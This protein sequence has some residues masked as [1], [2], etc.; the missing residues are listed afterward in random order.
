MLLSGCAE[1]L[2]TIPEMTTETSAPATVATTE[3]PTTEVEETEAMTTTETETEDES[4]SEPTT[5]VIKPGVPVM[6]ATEAPEEGEGTY[7]I[8]GLTVFEP[9]EH[10]NAYIDISQVGFLAPD[11]HTKDGYI[12]ECEFYDMGYRQW[13]VSHKL[14][15][16]P[17]ATPWVTEGGAEQTVRGMLTAWEA[18][19]HR[20]GQSQPLFVWERGK[21]EPVRWT[22][23]KNLRMLWSK[24]WDGDMVRT[25]EFDYGLGIHHYLQVPAEEEEGLFCE[26]DGNYYFP[27]N[28]CLMCLAPGAEE[29]KTIVLDTNFYVNRISNIYMYPTKVPMAIVRGVDDAGNE[30][31]ASVNLRTGEVA[32]VGPVNY[33]ANSDDNVLIMNSFDNTVSSEVRIYHY[34]FSD[35]SYMADGNVELQAQ[36]LSNGYTLLYYRVPLSAE[37]VGYRVYLYKPDHLLIANSRLDV[38]SSAWIAGECLLNAEGKIIIPIALPDGSTSFFRWD[39]VIKQATEPALNVCSVTDTTRYKK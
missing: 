3:A 25:T 4:V 35:V 18:D 34:G 24:V 37:T 6:G 7:G 29:P 13:V 16:E 26:L 21:E 22:L 12:S 39:P 8:V 5:R 19:G 14:T 33:Y 15:D 27:K 9:G 17:N 28:G 38:P 32:Y 11:A 36:Q 10:T 30:N 2:S 23:E 20:A 31:A 1:P